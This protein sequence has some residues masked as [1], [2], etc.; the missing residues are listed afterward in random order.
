MEGLATY[1]PQSIL[2]FLLDNKQGAASLQAMGGPADKPP[3]KQTYTTCVLF[4]GTCMSDLLGFFAGVFLF[5]FGCFGLCALRC[6]NILDMDML[7]PVAC[8]GFHDTPACFICVCRLLTTPYLPFLSL[9][10][11][12][13]LLFYEPWADNATS[14]TGGNQQQ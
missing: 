9:H 11:A 7:V 13:R 5:S 10:I 8:F 3:F 2:T 14:S 1:I 4:A 6:A 12:S